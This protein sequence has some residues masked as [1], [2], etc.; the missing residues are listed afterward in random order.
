MERITRR[1]NENF[2][3]ID[4]EILKDKEISLK[5]KAIHITVMALPESWDFSINGIAAILKEG[6]SAIVSAIVELRQHGYCKYVKRQNSKGHFVHDYIFYQNKALG[7]ASNPETENPLVEN[8]AVENP[9][10]E[11]R[12]Q[13]KYLKNKVLNNKK[14]NPPISPKG[15]EQSEAVLISENN[16]FAEEKTNT[17]KQKKTEKNKQIVPAACLD[18]F[19]QVSAVYGAALGRN[20]KT[21]AEKIFCQKWREGKIPE[22]E[23]LLA[24]IEE[25][26]NS[27]DPSKNNQYKAG[28][29]TWISQE[30]WNDEFEPFAKEIPQGHGVNKSGQ[31]VPI[32]QLDARK[33][34]HH[35]QFSGR[36]Y[37][38]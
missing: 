5:A 3:I 11:N 33:P 27:L 16:N 28:I 21:E 24:K 20:K 23:R 10:L 34:A 29:Q 7:A 22:L 35:T 12:Q 25:Y 18:A 1:Q 15:E 38:I 37:A 6:R 2:T 13:L 32:N 17:A 26:K 9:A 19:A 31:V 36:S 4:N 14:N 8:P 30:R